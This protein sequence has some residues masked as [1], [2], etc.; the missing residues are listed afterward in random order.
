MTRA[1]L[2]LEDFGMGEKVGTA[3]TG[4]F[5]GEQRGGDE[6]EPE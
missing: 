1:G 3:T 2:G 4:Q 6:Q 5:P